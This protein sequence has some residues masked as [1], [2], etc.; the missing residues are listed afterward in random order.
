MGFFRKDEDLTAEERRRRKLQK[1]KLGIETLKN[2]NPLLRVLSSV[3]I[4]NKDISDATRQELESS[5]GGRFALGAAE[6]LE[7]TQRTVAGAASDVGRE[8]LSL[9]NLLADKTGIYDVDDELLE[10]RRIY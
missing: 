3:D 10:T 6:K 9:A 4:L 5:L 7:S 1:F 8:T 2:T